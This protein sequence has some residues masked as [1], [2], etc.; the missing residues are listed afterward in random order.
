MLEYE[1][2]CRKIERRG[3]WDNRLNINV[4]VVSGFGLFLDGISEVFSN[5]WVYGIWKL[6]L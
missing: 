1:G 2:M 5:V 6:W 4:D 3:F